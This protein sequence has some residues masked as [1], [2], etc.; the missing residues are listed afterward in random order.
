LYEDFPYLKGVYSINICQSD[1]D[2][3]IFIVESDLDNEIL[4]SSEERE[5]LELTLLAIDDVDAEEF[6]E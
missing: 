3:F 2:K 5:K 6:V 1:D 4:I